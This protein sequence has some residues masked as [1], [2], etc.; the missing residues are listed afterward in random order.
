MSRKWVHLLMAAGLVGLAACKENTS[1]SLIDN[2]TV[3]T[4]VA[5]SAGDAI[6]TAVET[7][8]G[9]EGAAALPAP[10]ISFDLLGSAGNTLTVTRTRTCYDANGAVVAGCTPIATVRKIVTH[11]IMDG[12]RTGSNS[13]TGGAT[14]NF[15]GA[16]HRV[17]EDTLTR[18]FNTATPP[19]ET[20][21]AHTGIGSSHDTTTFAAGNVNRTHVE[22]ASDSV[23][24]VMFNLPRATNP[25]PVSGKI[26]RNVAV[27]TS[28]TNGAKT[29][30]KDFTKRVEVDFPAD[31]QGNVTLLV[32]NKTCTLNLAT[33]AV[34]NCH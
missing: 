25:Y 30:T 24:A 20:A 4:D 32:D 28:V 3:T 1:P 7:M 14:S 6:A 26:I 33:H 10:P 15:A 12:S 8:T 13:V 27:H 34:T 18:I 16:V 31:A 9:N 29:E 19:V 21:R 2:T 23:L 11:V 17:S 5:A 22:A